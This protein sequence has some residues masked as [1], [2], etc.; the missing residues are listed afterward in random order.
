MICS[1]TRNILG[2]YRKSMEY[3]ALLI[4]NVQNLVDKAAI[5]VLG[6]HCALLKKGIELQEGL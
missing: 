6:D 4:E 2:K 1:L 5:W 3:I